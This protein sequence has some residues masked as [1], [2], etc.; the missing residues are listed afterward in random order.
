MAPSTHT[1]AV[2]TDKGEVEVKKVAV[3]KLA[4]GEVLVKVAAA[5]LNPTD[6]TSH[7]GLFDECC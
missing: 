1:A 5:A 2:V 6:C 7:G 4:E 3:P